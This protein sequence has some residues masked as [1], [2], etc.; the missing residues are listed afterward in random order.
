MRLLPRSSRRVSKLAQRRRKELYIKSGLWFLAVVAVFIFFVY[1]AHRPELQ[2][3]DISVDGN[4]V[5]T[6][7]EIQGVTREVLSGKYLWLFPRTNVFVYPERKLIAT[8]HTSF[9]RINDIEVSIP[10]LG[11]LSIVVTERSPFALWCAG[12]DTETEGIAPC[13]FLNDEGFIFAQAPEYTGN[14]F[15]QF[16][17]GGVD[18][19]PVGRWYL[20]DNDEFHRVNTFINAIRKLAPT[21]ISFT[22]LNADDA[23]ILMEDGSRLVFGRMQN[24][25]ELIENLKSILAT[26]ELD[27]VDDSV[28]D[29]IDLRFGNKVYFKYK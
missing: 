12:S 25:S 24:F 2:I 23:E 22:V 7:E 13:Y 14:V 3:S 20:V 8:L 16:Y 18:A 26:D 4:E 11:A 5:V 1:V 27:S 28:L 17:G 29:Y 9:Q 19:N 15:F 6:K 10:Q 21:P